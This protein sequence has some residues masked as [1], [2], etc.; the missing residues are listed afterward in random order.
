MDE[1]NFLEEIKT[2]EHPP[3]YGITQFVGENQRDFL[4]E[5]EESLPPPHDSFPDAGE[6]TKWLLGHVKKHHIPPSR[7]TQSQTLLAERRIIPYSTEVHW[8][9]QNYSY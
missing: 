2:W 3:W 6:A 4:G 9:H 8:R 5:S 7:W 1:S